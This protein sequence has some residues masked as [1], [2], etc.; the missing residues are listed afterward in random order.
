MIN[1]DYEGSFDPIH[2]MLILL[3]YKICILY[4]ESIYYVFSMS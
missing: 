4:I 3:S 1:G 2:Y